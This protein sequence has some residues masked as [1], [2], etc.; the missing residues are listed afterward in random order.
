MKAAELGDIESIRWVA[1]FYEGDRGLE[2]PRY[3]GGLVYKSS[4]KR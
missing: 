3:R 4:K 1:R 2:R